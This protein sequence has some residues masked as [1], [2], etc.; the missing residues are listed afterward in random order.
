MKITPR[1]LVILACAW[2]GL[3][4]L[5]I[6]LHPAAYL[7]FWTQAPLN[8]APVLARAAFLAIGWGAY[9][10]RGWIGRAS[11]GLA[12]AW[13]AITAALAV[14]TPFGLMSIA[15][16]ARHSSSILRGDAV[17][18]GVDALVMGFWSLLAWSWVVA[19]VARRQRPAP[20][21]AVVAGE[22]HLVHGGIA[23]ILAWLF[24]WPLVHDW[25]TPLR[26]IRTGYWTS[27]TAHARV[28]L[29]DAQ[30]EA[31][32]PQ[33]IQVVDD[34]NDEIGH[35]VAGQPPTHS[36]LEVH[37]HSAWYTATPV[38]TWFITTYARDGKVSQIDV[39]FYNGDLDKKIGGRTFAVR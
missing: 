16:V 1:L 17:T 6:A 31:L 14:L 12:I 23:L 9:A 4:L 37:A 24:A 21:G 25:L 29:T 38:A 7:R 13:T 28:V 35:I 18:A 8:L 22:N 27:D 3:P 11:L 32:S 39:R 30:R 15:L 33:E 2:C 19:V 36:R 5:D 20:A 34:I 26:E 10:R